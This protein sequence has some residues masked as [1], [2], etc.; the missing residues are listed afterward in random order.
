MHD[1][2]LIR[3]R[4]ITLTDAHKKRAGF[5]WNQNEEETHEPWDY[6][7][8]ANKLKFRLTHLSASLMELTREEEDKY[9]EAYFFPEEI[10]DAYLSRLSE[11]AGIIDV[12]KIQL[13]NS[14]KIYFKIID[15]Q[16][17]LD[18]LRTGIDEI[19]SYSKKQIWYQDISEKQIFLWKD[20]L[21]NTRDS[22]NLTL[23]INASVIRLHLE[24]IEPINKNDVISIIQEKWLSGVASLDL[25]EGLFIT[26]WII[27]L[28]DVAYETINELIDKLANHNKIWWI[29]LD[30][31]LCT[32]EDPLYW[33]TRPIFDIK[34]REID[35]DLPIIAVIDSWVVRNQITGPILINDGID[36][37]STLD[38]YN[39]DTLNHWTPVAC[40]IAYG[41]TIRKYFIDRSIEKLIATNRIFPV[42]VFA[43]KNATTVDYDKIFEIWWLFWEKVNEYWIKIVNLSFCWRELDLY[44]FE[45]SKQAKILDRFAEVYNVIFTIATWNISKSELN[46]LRSKYPNYEFYN[47]ELSPDIKVN[48][49]EILIEEYINIK[50]PWELLSGINVWSLSRN[51]PSLFSKSYEIKNLSKLSWKSKFKPDIISMGGWDYSINGTDIDDIP[52]I[53]CS[54]EQTL[55]SLMVGWTSLTTPRI[56]RLLG[57]IQAKYSLDR[58]ES[59][60]CILLH[61]WSDYEIESVKEIDWTNVEFHKSFLWNS[62]YNMED[63]ISFISD[64]ENTITFLIEWE[65]NSNQVI[66]YKIP[67]SKIPWIW[68]RG[69]RNKLEIKAS[70]C[71]MP[72]SWISWNLYKDENIFH[73]SA[74]V[75]NDIISPVV[76]VRRWKRNYENQ[77]VAFQWNER[78]IFIWWTYDY[79]TSINPTF[80]Q[81]SRLILKEDFLSS[82][83][84]SNELNVSIRWICDIATIKKFSVVISVKDLWETNQIRNFLN[85]TI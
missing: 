71:I 73:I 43:D 37:T 44:E 10:S 60:K 67:V 72:T 54:N 9:L 58:A 18:Y 84:S 62:V 83:G 21:L 7:Y 57:I 29:R 63:E 1:I 13:N 31:F 40:E 70:I 22:K 52:F 5:W 46:L 66:K 55:L 85:I 64:D 56:S 15:A 25:W 47:R 49:N 33:W 23:H 41:E 32:M 16:Q 50:T 38:L 6:I 81:K 3:W 35:S 42:K 17:L 36:Y 26:N 14:Q 8:I 30:D 2:S 65:I 53:Y 75:H 80:S 45:F 78:N 27:S 68:W 34:I 24:M 76:T 28:S 20:F 4:G 77:S 19:L 82:L 51:T 79:Y 74:M 39:V 69:K 59:M 48:S 61:K 11:K 12:K